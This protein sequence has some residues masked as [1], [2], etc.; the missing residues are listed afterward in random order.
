MIEA[1]GFIMWCDQGPGCFARQVAKTEVEVKDR[2]R[3]SNWL[4]EDDYQLCPVHRND[5]ELVEQMKKDR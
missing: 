2:A 4:V 3:M 1:L 5:T